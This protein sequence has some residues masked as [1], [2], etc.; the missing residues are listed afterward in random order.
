[1][2]FVKLHHKLLN[3]GWA[4]DPN[5]VA[6][7]VRILLEA[8]WKDEEWHGALYERGSFPTSYTKLSQDTG[9]SVQSVRTCLERLKKSGEITCVSTNGGTKII[10]NKWDYYQ[11]SCDDA[12]TQD[13]T[14]V[15]SDQHEGNTEPTRVQHEPNTEPTTL[16]EYKNTRSKE[17]KE[18]IY[19]GEFQNVK[20]TA[21]EFS[22]LKEEFPTDYQDR[23]ERVSSYCAST[24]KKYKNY[25]ATIRNWARKDPKPQEEPTRRYEQPW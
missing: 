13:N 24:G 25:L 11:G 15:T 7:W 1:M 2:S 17:K 3:W 22:K 12:N 5:M 8:N 14:P 9:L 20:F 21:D 23:I 19:L 6:L 16:K 4:D 18:Y 10:V